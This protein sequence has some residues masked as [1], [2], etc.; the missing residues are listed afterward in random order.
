MAPGVGA[1]GVDF[2]GKVGVVMLDGSGPVAAVGKFGNKFFDE[3]GFADFR[4][5]L[6]S[7]ELSEQSRSRPRL[8]R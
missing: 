1:L 7:G 6:R 5:T 4:D 3:R 2:Y 8:S